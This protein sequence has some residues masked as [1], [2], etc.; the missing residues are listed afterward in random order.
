M[1]PA[2]KIIDVRLH[3]FPASRDLSAP[4]KN[5]ANL[6]IFPC[7]SPRIKMISAKPWWTRG[8]LTPVTEI[9]S[10]LHKFPSFSTSSINLLKNFTKGWRWL[11]ALEIENSPLRRAFPL[12]L[13][14]KL[15]LRVLLL[16]L[17]R[18]AVGGGSYFEIFM[19]LGKM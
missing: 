7:K 14:G 6:H 17:R 19:R 4:T 3:G 13:R 8:S 5:A 16:P 11:A 1:T 15:T 10:R 2:A 18:V 9:Y 12:S